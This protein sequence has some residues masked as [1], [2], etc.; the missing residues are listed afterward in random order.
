MKRR[1]FVK[2]STLSAA[3]LLASRGLVNRSVASLSILNPR[4]RVPVSFII[5]DSTAL[6]NLAYYGIPQFKEIFPSQYLQDWKKLPQE[7]PD[8]FVLEFLEWC[9][10]NGVKGKY[11]MV[12]YPA[13]TGWLHRFIPGW[14]K[15]EL[16]ESLK[17]IRELAQPNWDIHSEMISHTRVINTKT[18]MPFPEASADYMENWEWSQTK[19]ADELGEYIAYSLQI[20][21]DAGLHC[22]GVTTPGGFAGRN[23]QNL[24]KGTLYAVKEVYGGKVAHFF[25]DLTTDP[26]LSVQPQVMHAEGLDGDQASCSVHII[27]CTGDWFGGWDGLT[28]GDA[29]RFITP[30]LQ[31][32]RMV[33]VIE[34][35]EPAIMVC[36]WPGIYYNGEKVG[37]EIFKTVVDRLHQ[38]YDHLVWMKLSDIASY[39]AAREFTKMEL[40]D[41]AVNLNA[42]FECKNFT[43][44]VDGR[45]KNPILKAGEKTILL[46]EDRNLSQNSWTRQDTALKLCFDLERGRSTL[47]LES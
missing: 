24:A 32:G 7:I 42:P 14:T 25:R 43:I 40:V 16:E 37:F 38:K 19:S 34:S 22:D 31:E 10:M 39:W 36:H 9:D 13:C 11:S 27:G 45:Y 46:K 41:G 20:L 30:D 26:N 18:G 47:I 29:D 3:S 8:S 21:K 23:K 5:D 44:Q 33:E 15:K 12:P 1:K 28:P 6:V 4:D 35:G 2:D 17:I